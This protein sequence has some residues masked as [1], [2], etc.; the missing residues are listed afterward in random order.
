MQEE[1]P[2]KVDAFKTLLRSRKEPNIEIGTHCSDPYPCEFMDYCW[3]HI[4]DVSVFSLSNMRATKKFELYAQGIIE[5]HQL[6]DGYS[7]TAAQQLQVR[8]W[9]KDR[10]HTEPD[11]IRVWL[12]QLTRPLYFMDFET[13]MPAVPLYKQ[14]R[15]FQ[16]IPF[17]FSV[18]VQANPRSGLK[19]LEYLGEPETDPRPAFIKQLLAALGDKGSIL[20]Y[21]KAFEITRLRE[22]QTLY[23]R[24][25]KPIDQVISRIID[26]MEPFQ[27]KW[28]YHPAMNGSYSIKQVLPA[29]VPELS[30]K[31]LEIGEGGTA[32]AA[33]E[34]LL[35]INDQNQR[36]KI[37]K[38]LLEYCGR[39]TLA[40]VRILEKLKT[41]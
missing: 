29:L 23:P 21:N 16:H 33:F 28:Y 41:I 26:L 34:G 30:Y 3:S 1:I 17:Q 20:V 9:Q 18:H 27:Q 6:P 5:F 4:P 31:D 32:M 38:S 22:L 37:R 10:L 15:P 35:K 12:K 40:M 13:F 7:L 25:K 19:H 11:K 36:H 39:D 24:L 8:C 14:S 2:A